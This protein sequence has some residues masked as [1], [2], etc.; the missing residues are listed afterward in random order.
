[1]RHASISSIE[2]EGNKAI[3]K[4][5]PLE[6]P[7][8]SPGLLAEGE[9]FQRAT[10]EGVRNELQTPVRGP[11]PLLAEINAEVIRSRATA[12]R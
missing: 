5:D 3:S 1:M 7:G 11:G 10:L 12:S 2:I 6:R 4:E 8:N 9:I